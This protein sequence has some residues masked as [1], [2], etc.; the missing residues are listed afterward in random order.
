[1]SELFL[2]ESTEWFLQKN[3]VACLKKQHNIFFL[4]FNSKLE[5][6]K[7]NICITYIF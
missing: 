3:T 5:L 4:Y 6:N 1:M 2:W 7:N